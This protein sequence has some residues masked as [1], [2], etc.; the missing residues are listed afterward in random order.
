MFVNRFGHHTHALRC[1][2]TDRRQKSIVNFSLCHNYGWQRLPRLGVCTGSE[3]NMDKVV[4][5]MRKEEKTESRARGCRRCI[6]IALHRMH[7]SQQIRLHNTIVCWQ[8]VNTIRERKQRPH[9]NGEDEN[10]IGPFFLLLSIAVALGCQTV[11]ERRTTRWNIWVTFSLSFAFRFIVSTQKNYIFSTNEWPPSP[12]T[13]VPCAICCRFRPNEFVVCITV[14][15]V[16]CPHHTL[17]SIPLFVA[18]H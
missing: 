10:R 17:R 15:S 18:D 6:V 4:N 1:I 7:W 9:E 16:A 8:K 14:L 13:C 2:V 11:C 3:R 12:W 5:G